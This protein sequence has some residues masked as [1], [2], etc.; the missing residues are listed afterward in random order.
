MKIKYAFIFALASAFSVS[1]IQAQSNRASNRTK[2]LKE[3]REYKY[4][5]LIEETEMT[6]AQQNEFFPLYSAMEKEI[7]QVNV[8]A[9]QL[10]SKVS[11]SKSEVSELEY[12]KA[13]DALAEAKSREAQIELDY[14]H[15][16]SKIL[17]KKQL[18]QLKRAE[19]RFTRDMLGHYK[20]GQATKKK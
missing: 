6:K 1:V 19:N 8:E 16:F 18:F 17:S 2:W 3:V 7:Y 12:E 4:D 9:R 13:A 10:E 11:N 5:K 20:R 15:K 14:Y